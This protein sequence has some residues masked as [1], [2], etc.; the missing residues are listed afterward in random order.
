MFAELAGKYTARIEIIKDNE[1]VDG[2]S[3]LSIM[4]LAAEQGTALDIEA[5]GEDA[6]VAIDALAELFE[7]G[8]LSGEEE[9]KTT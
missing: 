3:I 4:T 2:K 1:R 6:E 8:F 5:V 7:Q 9:P